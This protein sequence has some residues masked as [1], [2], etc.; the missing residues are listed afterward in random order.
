MIFTKPISKFAYLGGRWV[1]SF[2]ATVFTFSGALLGEFLGTLAPRADHA[3]IALN[4]FGWYFQPFFSIIVVQ[5]FFLG[6]LFFTIA[7]LSRRIFIISLQGAAFFMLYLIGVTIFSAT[8]SL[9]AFLVGHFDP[10]GFLY[11]ERH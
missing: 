9:G 5:I 8:R 6:S 7:A 4:H 2:V 10:I 3:R 1:G 11:N